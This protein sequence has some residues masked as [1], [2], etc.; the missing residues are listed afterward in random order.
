ARAL[1]LEDCIGNFLPGK[2]ADFVVLD[3]NATPEMRCRMD[4]AR[5]I[6]E[7]LFA[8]MMMGD[9]RNVAA[10]HILGEPAQLPKRGRA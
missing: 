6:D 2:E 7:R 5:T 1:H 9:E 4:T 10:T 3:W 8:L